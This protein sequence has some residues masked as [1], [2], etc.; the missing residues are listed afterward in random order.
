MI[1]EMKKLLEQIRLNNMELSKIKNKNYH[2]LY[3]NGDL[4][5]VEEITRSLCVSAASV[6]TFVEHLEASSPLSPTKGN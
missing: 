5:F 6:A 3:N 4:R 2:E 1:E